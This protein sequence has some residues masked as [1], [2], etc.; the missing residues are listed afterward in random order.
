MP[1]R[2]SSVRFDLKAEGKALAVGEATPSADFRTANPDYFRAAGIPLL[3]GRPFST[4]DRWGGGRV[5]I[6]NRTLADRLFPGEDPL[7]KRIAWTGDVLRFTPI[8]GDWRTIVGV[9]ATPDGG[10]TRARAVVQPFRAGAG[11]RWRV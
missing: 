8:S 5:V 11:A 9:V 4:T 1:L 2:G 3:Q 7:G 6:V 10:W